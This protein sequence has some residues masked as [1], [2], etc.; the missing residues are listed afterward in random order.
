MKGILYS[1]SKNR[2]TESYDYN[3]L[4]DR[5]GFKFKA[6]ELKKTWDNLWVCKDDWEPRHSLDFY[7][8]KND[9]HLLPYT[10]PDDA[11]VDIMD[12]SGTHSLVDP[13]VSDV[14]ST[15]G[16][17]YLWFNTMTG[18]TFKVTFV[19]PDYLWVPLN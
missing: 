12:T 3:V 4:C 17:G 14:A 2:A 16:A 8:T 6:S 5:C 13:G 19:N 11:E 1:M 10:R 7:K 18:R 15:Y 9:A